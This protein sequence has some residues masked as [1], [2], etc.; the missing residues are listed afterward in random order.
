MAT[1]AGLWWLFLILGLVLSVLG[2][3]FFI[4]RATLIGLVLHLMGGASWILFLI[5]IIAR[6]IMFFKEA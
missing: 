2:M 5:A 4:M 6:L 3:V 1:L